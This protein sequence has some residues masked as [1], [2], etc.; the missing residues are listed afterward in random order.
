MPEHIHARKDRDAAVR[1]F[2]N[3]C[4][5][6]FHAEVRSLRPSR[7]WQDGI[8]YHPDWRF[9]TVMF[10]C[11]ASKEAQDMNRSFDLPEDEDD[12]LVKEAYSFYKFGVCQDAALAQI[13]RWI[14]TCYRHSEETATL[15]KV[16]A[17][18]VARLS[19]AQIAEM[20]GASERHIEVLV[21]FFYDA[22]PYLDSKEFIQLQV[23]PYAYNADHDS[24]GVAERKHREWMAAAYQNGWP[25]LQR[26]LYPQGEV[27]ADQKASADRHI[28]G[29][30]AVD[31]A[32]YASTLIL[33]PNPRPC[34]FERWLQLDTADKQNQALDKAAGTVGGN[35]WI[36]AFHNEFLKLG[37]LPGE[38][39]E[40]IADYL[41]TS[42]ELV[43]KEETLSAPTPQDSTKISGPLGFNK[44][45]GQSNGGSLSFRR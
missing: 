45:A 32:R 3:E 6:T 22:R 41:N 35:E 43:A 7:N 25:G 2:Y 44:L 42:S 4:R 20:I 30:F 15:P 16:R 39:R 1:L 33:H 9:T 24:L 40:E 14:D 12:V 34:G 27:T 13:F 21:N 28:R 23:I 8:D 17:M 36:A 38:I 18:V 19:N 29:A 11:K 37:Q 31:A 10:Y 26:F 5:P